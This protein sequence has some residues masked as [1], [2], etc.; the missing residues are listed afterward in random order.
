VLRR[1]AF[2]NV[3]WQVTRCDPMCHC[4]AEMGSREKLQT[5]LTFLFS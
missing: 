2:I 4:T 5:L 1:G 3:G